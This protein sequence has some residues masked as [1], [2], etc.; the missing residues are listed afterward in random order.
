MHAKIKDNCVMLSLLQSPCCACWLAVMIY[1]DTY[2]TEAFLIK[3]VSPVLFML[4]DK[5]RFVSQPAEISS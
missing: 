3:F 5:N 4:G 1:W 2:E